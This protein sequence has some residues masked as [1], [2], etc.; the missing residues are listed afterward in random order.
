MSHFDSAEERTEF[1]AFA[2]MFR[3]QKDQSL[4]NDERL[5]MYGLYKQGTEGSAGLGTRPAFDL[6]KPARTHMWDAWERETGLTPRE[7]RRQYME[8][9][10]QHLR[11]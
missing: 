1:L 8:L 2:E 9:A 10:V 5:K 4:S 6:L 7:A 11:A 3:R